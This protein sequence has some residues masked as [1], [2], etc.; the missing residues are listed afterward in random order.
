MTRPKI[1]IAADRPKRIPKYQLA[2]EEAGGEAQ[3]FFPDSTWENALD[4]SDGLLL[5]G[6]GDIDAAEF[7]E[8]N[9]P[10]VHGVDTN[11]DKMELTLT[12]YA[13]Q[14]NIPVLGIC[15]GLQVMNVALGGTLIQDI[16]DHLRTYVIHDDTP[17]SRQ[18]LVH[19]VEI[20]QGT[21]LFR[22]VGTNRIGVNSF[23]HQAIK[24]L[25]KG[26]IKT[27]WADD[28][29]IEAV[30]LPPKDARFFLAV[31]WHPEEFVKH[32]GMFD[33]LFE[34]FVDSCRKI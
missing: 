1:A 31:Q 8:E 22:I 21:M 2:I 33:S 19:E 16:P 30:E 12:R 28:G 14:K 29:V 11:R 23:H 7:H 32:G 18:N 24:D 5:T 17:N 10:A 26:L 13:L 4:S 25:G 27:A 6:G 34:A 3:S 15:R 9:H 20:Q